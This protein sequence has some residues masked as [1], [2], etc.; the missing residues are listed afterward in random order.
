[1]AYQR[2]IIQLNI[3]GAG[4]DTYTP[5]FLVPDGSSKITAQFV[6]TGLL[7][8]PILSLEQ[9]TDGKNFDPVLDLSSVPLTLSLN[10]NNP[11]ATVNI[12]NLLTMSIRFK[13]DFDPTE[14]G[15]ITSVTYLTE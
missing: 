3:S 6:Y 4:G 13:I 7:V 11:S 2:K 10:K 8:N 5:V 14:T 1:M 15:S 12:V 9:S